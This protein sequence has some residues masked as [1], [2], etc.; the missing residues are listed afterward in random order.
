VRHGG[1]KLIVDTE[2]KLK[3]KV[4]LYNLDEDVGE[5]KDLVTREPGRAA[6]M[7]ALLEK[8]VFDGRSTPGPKQPNDGK[9]KRFLRAE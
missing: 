5:K 1:W 8:I 6:E 2:G 7:Q 3:T 4:Q 9:L